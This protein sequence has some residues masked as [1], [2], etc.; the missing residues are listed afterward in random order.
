MVVAVEVVAAGVVVAVVVTAAVLVFA[1]AVVVAAGVAVVLVLAAA[2]TGGTSALLALTEA[3]RGA[4]V[5][6]A[7]KAGCAMLEAYT[8]WH[9]S[10]KDVGPRGEAD[11]FFWEALAPRAMLPETADHRSEVHRLHRSASALHS[12]VTVFVKASCVSELGSST[13]A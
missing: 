12:G 10:S 5:V 13:A 3:F 2:T 11:A 9:H 4:A 1:I 6:G 8:S 7:A